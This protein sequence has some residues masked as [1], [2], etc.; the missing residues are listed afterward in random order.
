MEETVKAKYRNS[1]I[2]SKLMHGKPNLIEA[3]LYAREAGKCDWQS[4][5]EFDWRRSYEE[6]K[7]P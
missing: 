3:Q 5:W 4:Q 6:R 1:I 7:L 2:C